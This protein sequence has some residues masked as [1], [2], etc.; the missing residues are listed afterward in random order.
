MRIVITGASGNVGTSVIEALAGDDRVTEI[1]GVARR[2]VGWAHAKTRWVHA[3]VV[4]ADGRF[5]TASETE[6][7]DLF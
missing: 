3:D 1:V 7:A 6:N 4:T 5:V 2:P